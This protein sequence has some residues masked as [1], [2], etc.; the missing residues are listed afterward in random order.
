[1]EL[2][3]RNACVVETGTELLKRVLVA[4]GEMDQRWVVVCGPTV[5]VRVLKC[6]VSRLNGLLREWQVPSGDGVQV[7]V[8]LRLHDNLTCFRL[9]LQRG[10][11]WTGQCCDVEDTDQAYLDPL[12]EAI[13]AILQ[14]LC[15]L[16]FGFTRSRIVA[17]VQNPFGYLVRSREP[18]NP[19]RP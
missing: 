15:Q 9:R 5:E 6:R 16:F 4:N 14:E 3:R 17:R 19:I 13:L 10:E 18:K 11:V 1:M 2:S 7:V 8:D 12:D